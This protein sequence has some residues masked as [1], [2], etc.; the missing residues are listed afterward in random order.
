METKMCKYSSTFLITFKFGHAR[1]RVGKYFIRARRRRVLVL[2]AYL[3]KYFCALS[4]KSLISTIT[5]TR[6][7]FS[8]FH[9]FF[10][11][12]CVLSLVIFFSLL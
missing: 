5:Y 12:H 4:R 10:I 2:A 9:K 1:G 3:E 8:W 11:A 6:H 7:W